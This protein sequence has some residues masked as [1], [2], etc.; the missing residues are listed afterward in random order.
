LSA[1]KTLLLPH[2]VRQ[3]RT[4]VPHPGMT[5]VAHMDQQSGSTVRGSGTRS[6]G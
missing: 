4:H 3:P 5:G 2:L 6:L 1:L